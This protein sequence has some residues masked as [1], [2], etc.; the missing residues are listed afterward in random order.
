L[1]AFDA[2]GLTALTTIG[3]SFMCDCRALTAFDA[4]GLTALTTVGTV[5]LPTACVLLVPRGLFSGGHPLHERHNGQVL[6]T[7]DEVLGALCFSEAAER[8]HGAAVLW[9]PPCVVVVAYGAAR[10]SPAA[11]VG[12]AS[13]RVRRQLDALE[14][15][16]RYMNAG[17]HPGL[18]QRPDED[19]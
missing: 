4:S 3:D 14:R 5:E 15:T 12:L 1:T 17:N 10:P 2:S 11:A 9:P 16:W 13:Q 6:P 7:P 8:T 19:G 18:P